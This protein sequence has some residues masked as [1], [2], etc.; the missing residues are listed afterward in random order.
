MEAALERPAV[1]D[2]GV[3]VPVEGAELVDVGVH[4]VGVRLGVGDNRPPALK[5]VSG[6]VGAEAPEQ[7]SQDQALQL[8]QMGIPAAV[9][10]ST[11]TADAQSSVMRKARAGE[12][13]LLYLSPERLAR[14]D[15][16]AWLR[17]VAVEFFAI[18]EAHCISEWGHEFR[19]EYRQLS[20]LRVNFPERPIAAFTASATRRVRHAVVLLGRSVRRRPIRAVVVGRRSARRAVLV[21][22]CV[23]GDEPAGIAVTRALRTAPPPPGVALWLVDAVN[24]DG[25]AA[26]ILQNARG[27]DLNRNS[28]WHWRSLDRRGGLFWSGPRPR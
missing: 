11:L 24:P 20:A 21:V 28:P 25:C 23:H 4:R 6:V 1:G 27:V 13:R 12:Y 18:D 3:L 14:A 9:L 7:F 16:I 8:S 17:Q 10:N 22:G 5:P 2:E 15:C 26:G 19:P